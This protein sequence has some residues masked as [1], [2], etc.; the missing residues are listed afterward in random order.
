MADTDAIAPETVVPETPKNNAGT[1]PT[2]TV[3]PEEKK[4]D[5]A[6]EELRKQLE[7]ERMRANQLANKLQAEEDAK[8]AAK[9]KE[10]EEQSEFK[11]LF[12]Q[13]KAK[14]EELEA[15]KLRQ[16]TQ[17]QIDE[18]KAQIVS[19]YSDDVKALADDAGIT[20]QG[21]S[22]DEV[23]AFKSTLDKF[24]VR[25]GK[26]SVSPNNP[27]NASP[28]EA[29]PTG[30]E[31]RKILNDPKLRDEYYRKKGGVTAAMMETQ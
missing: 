12:E 30:E 3:V 21:T 29:E 4:T 27:G 23:A 16:E 25:L 5:T 17:R 20:L 7:Q 2:P 8:A 11:T 13:E 18:A 28:K 14:R 24:Q 22:E 31:L 26:Q 1:P 19:D 6:V 9:Q 10:L 15:E